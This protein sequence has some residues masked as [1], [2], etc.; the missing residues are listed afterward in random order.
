MIVDRILK[1]AE[2]QVLAIR[3]GETVIHAARMFEQ[4]RV[5]LAVVCDDKDN[6]I[7]VVS[8]G[9]I[10][11]AIGE[12]GAEALDLPVRMIMTQD[13]VTCEGS[14]HV[15]SAI[16]KMT[17]RG[18]R[19]LPVVEGGKLKGII[20]KREALELLYEEA[21]LDFAQLRN[22]VFKTGGRY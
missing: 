10:V 20:E 16:I 8:L 18:V 4:K 6:V 3:P 13:V 11:H 7:G 5:G 9:D 22:Y 14:D 21:A 15:E 19:H 17:E 2:H 12:R 1:S